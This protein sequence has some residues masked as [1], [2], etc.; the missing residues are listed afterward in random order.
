MVT[1]EIARRT[2]MKAVVMEKRW[3]SK[4]DQTCSMR[5]KNLSLP[6]QT[7]TAAHE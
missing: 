1:I 3:E 4:V 2:P 7:W 5:N 6:I